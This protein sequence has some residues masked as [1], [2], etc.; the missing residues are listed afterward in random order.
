[1]HLF[2][3]CTN[4]PTPKTVLVGLEDALGSSFSSEPCAAHRLSLLG[5]NLNKEGV[6]SGTLHVL[7]LGCTFLKTTIRLPPTQTTLV[8]DTLWYGTANPSA[9]YNDWK[10]QKKTLPVAT[11]CKRDFGWI[12]QW[13]PGA[14]GQGA[15]CI[16]PIAVRVLSAHRY[17]WYSP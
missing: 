15:T 6:G 4:S 7:S 10:S 14:S 13:K 8:L 5:L 2:F 17:H 12:M 9:S 11:E 3:F 16:D 1:M